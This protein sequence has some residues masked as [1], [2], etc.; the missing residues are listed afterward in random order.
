MNE[1]W[2]LAFALAAGAVLGAMF[3]GALWWTVRRAVSSKRVA[4]WFIGSLLLRMGL[5][6]AGLY[7]VAAGHWQRLLLCLFGFVLARIV[8]IWLTRPPEENPPTRPL[9]ESRAP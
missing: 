5:A 2:N 7:F 4:L 3:Y 8:V 1:P 6:L 9:E